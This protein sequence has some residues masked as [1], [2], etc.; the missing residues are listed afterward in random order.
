MFAA[1]L[2]GLTRKSERRIAGGFAND[3]LASG[4]AVRDGLMRPRAVET[5]RVPVVIVG[6][7][8]AG[9]SAGWRLD[10]RGFGDFVLLELHDRPG[11]NARW[12]E[13]SVTAFP[14]AAHYVP[15]PNRESTLMRELLA[16]L[17]VLHDGKP[18][19]RYLC[20]SPQERLYLHGRWQE[21]LEPEIAATARDRD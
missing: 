9:L 11:G 7:G 20:H 10:K 4:H 17:G 5:I 12:G 6:G 21:G 15:V 3:G 8:I 1:A 18:E 16:E 2:I 14:W 13:N 19:E